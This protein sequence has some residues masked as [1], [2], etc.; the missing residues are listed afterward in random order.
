MSAI[1]GMS[2]S[3]KRT[4]NMPIFDL[5]SDAGVTKVSEI[6]FDSS[7]LSDL[8]E[9]DDNVEHLVNQTTK[10][11]LRT[12]ADKVGPNDIVEEVIE[13]EISD[14][15]L[16]FIED[17]IENEENVG[18]VTDHNYIRIEDEEPNFQFNLT[19]KSDIKWVHQ[20][21]TSPVSVFNNTSVIEDTEV[22]IPLNYF[23]KYVPEEVFSLMSEMTN[24]YALQKNKSNFKPTNSLEIKILIGLH[25]YTGVLKFARL[26]MY[27]NCKLK[28]YVFLESMSRDRFFE[29]R[30]N[31]HLVNNLEIPNNNK[32]KFIKVRPLYDSI[33]KRCNELQ[34]EEELCVDEAII[35]FTGQLSVK[36]YMKGKPDPWGIKVFMLNGKSGL[37]Y[38]FILYQGKDTEINENLL[39]SFGFSS[40]VVLHLSKRLKG[41]LGLKLYFDNFFNSYHLLQALKQINIHAAGTARVNRFGKAPLL[42]DKEA[43]RLDRGSSIEVTSTDGITLLKW[44]DNKSVVLAS[45]FVGSGEIDQVE[46][47]DKSNKQY[48]CIDRPEIVR[49]YNHSMGGVDLFDQLISYYRIFIRSRKWTLRAI[50]HAIDFAIVQSWLEYKRDANQLQIPEKKIMDLLEFRIRVADGLIYCGNLVNKKKR[51][52]PSSSN[53]PPETAVVQR[54]RGE[55]RPVTE[56]QFDG[57]DHLPL[58]D[59]CKL[60]VRCKYPKC[61]GK[62]RI[63]CQKCRVHLCLSKDR[64]C[65]LQFHSK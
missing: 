51:G 32:D 52:R 24:I 40:S 48:I 28:V 49:R 27:W 45:N 6:L 56:I 47:W 5:E 7:D 19:K 23:K 12:G 53:T 38:D 34:L 8:S 35:P 29:L 9:D 21:G 59:N 60:P 13:E 61:T 39:K 57:V 31:L 10:L 33:R 43:M 14:D 16:Q 17:D 26:R 20:S 1:P 46:R 42:P 11:I 41:V 30:S 55:C 44:V 2:K 25:I 15:F 3:D 22:L 4:N 65:F 58:H 62:S 63:Q 37:V 64:N 54:R 50:F 36:Q 18:H